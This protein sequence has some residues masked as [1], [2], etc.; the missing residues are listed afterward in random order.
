MIRRLLARLIRA[1]NPDRPPWLC[2]CTKE[3]P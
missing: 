1:I 3:A 2:E